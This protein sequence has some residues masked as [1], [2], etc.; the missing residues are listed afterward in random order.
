MYQTVVYNLLMP[1]YFFFPI[2]KF[3]TLI[4]VYFLKA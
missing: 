2:I 3:S 1:E 4:K